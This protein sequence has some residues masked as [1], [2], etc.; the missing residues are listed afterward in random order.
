MKNEPSS[1][2]DGCT[3]ILIGI[4]TVII[5]LAIAKIMGPVWAVT[6]TFGYGL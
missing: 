2:N 3:S 4:A 6:D 5:I 1:V